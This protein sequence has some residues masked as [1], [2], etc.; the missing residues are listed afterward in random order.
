MDVHMVSM[1][2]RR[3]YKHRSSEELS[4]TRSLLTE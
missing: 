3:T 2:A 4:L 1:H